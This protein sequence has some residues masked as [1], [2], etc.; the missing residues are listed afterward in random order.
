ME[1][2][3]IRDFIDVARVARVATASA[4]GE[5]HNVPVCPILAHPPGE[6]A[7]RVFFATG[8]GRKV[9]NIRANP[10]VCLVFDDY[11]ELWT[12]LRQVLVFGGA[13]VIEGDDPRFL[14]LRDAHYVKYPQ[15]PDMADGIEPGESVIIGVTIERIVADGF[16]GTG[17]D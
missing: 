2:G 15:Y 4:D 12:A 13:E 7:E 14:A 17:T 3:E 9:R 11:I 16:E 1:A 6:P 10:R 8:E 5:P